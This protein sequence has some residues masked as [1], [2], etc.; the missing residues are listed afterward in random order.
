MA[1]SGTCNGIV[2]NADAEHACAGPDGQRVRLEG[3]RVGARWLTSEEDLARWVG[4]LTPSRDSGRASRS[5][6]RRHRASEI[7]GK[8]HHEKETGSAV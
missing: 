7:A 3:V 8:T 6:A 1:K 5:P 4:R 2:I